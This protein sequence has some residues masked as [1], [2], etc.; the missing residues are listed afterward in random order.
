VLAILLRSQLVTQLLQ[1]IPPSEAQVLPGLRSCNLILG[2]CHEEQHVLV[3]Q[4]RRF[5]HLCFRHCS[6]GS[7]LGIDGTLSGV[8]TPQLLPGC[9]RSARALEPC[10]LRIQPIPPRVRTDSGG[11]R[12]FGAIGRRAGGLRH[13]F[14]AGGGCLGCGPPICPLRVVL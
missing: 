2:H 12:V 6:S 1:F 11:P 13:V 4:Q 10:L 9:L 14:G 7:S 3:L 8:C 5:L